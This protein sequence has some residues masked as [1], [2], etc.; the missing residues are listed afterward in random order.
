MAEKRANRVPPPPLNREVPRFVYTAADVTRAKGMQN[1]SPVVVPAHP[2]VNRLLTLP[3]LRTR[4]VPTVTNQLVVRRPGVPVA[5][6]PTRTPNSTPPPTAVLALKRVPA[7][8]TA[9]GPVPGRIPARSAVPSPLG[10]PKTAVPTVTGPVRTIP[11]V[12]SGQIRGERR[13]P[14]VPIVAPVPVARSAAV[15]TVGTGVSRPVFRLPTVAP[16]PTGRSAAI[17]GPVLSSA[18]RQWRKPVRIPSEI[19]RVQHP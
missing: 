13:V 15:P 5:T 1:G 9:S 4:P 16:T 18:P 8:P 11:P 19:T 2:V 7:A 10:T 12:I 14:G 3:Q 6:G 17:S